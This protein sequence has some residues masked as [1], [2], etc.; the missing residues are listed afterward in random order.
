MVEINR[1]MQIH[2]IYCNLQSLAKILRKIIF[3]LLKNHDSPNL[4][5]VR[6]ICSSFHTKVGP[7]LRSVF[8]IL[9]LFLIFRDRRIFLRLVY[10][11][12]VNPP[13]TITVCPVIKSEMFE[14]KKTTAPATSSGLATLFSGMTRSKDILI[15]SGRDR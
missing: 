5:A 7:A 4:L 6:I 9:K 12:I 15:F 3:L 13:L 11:C 1:N 10:P 2:G 8:S 14:A